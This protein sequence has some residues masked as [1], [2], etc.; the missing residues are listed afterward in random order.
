MLCQISKLGYTA[1]AMT[2]HPEHNRALTSPSMVTRSNH[3]GQVPFGVIA[4][5]D[6][7]SK[8]ECWGQTSQGTKRD[9]SERV[10]EDLLSSIRG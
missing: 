4:L 8:P 10:R 1:G 9:V 5:A 7:S 6:R 2:S 3:E